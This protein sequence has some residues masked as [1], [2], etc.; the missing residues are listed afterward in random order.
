MRAKP[1]PYDRQPSPD[2]RRNGSGQ[3]G[4]RRHEAGAAGD[5]GSSPG[6]L[7]AGGGSVEASEPLAFARL[8]IRQAVTNLSDNHSWHLTHHGTHRML[9]LTLTLPL[10]LTLTLTPHPHPHPHPTPIPIPIPHQ[11]ILNSFY[12]YVMRR[13]ARWYSMEMAGVVTYNGANIIKDARVLVNPTPTPT[14]HPHPHPPP[15][16]NPYPNPAPYP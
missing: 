11:C 4:R 2:P 9:T 15:H 16:P 8:K 10:T 14:P 13:G 3:A 6:S 1:H 5:E 12:G 7:E